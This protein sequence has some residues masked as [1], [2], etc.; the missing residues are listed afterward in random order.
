MS[1]K[2]IKDEYKRLEGD[3]HIKQKRKE[4]QREMAQGRQS[5]AVPGADVVEALESGLRPDATPT[6][7]NKSDQDLSVQSGADQ[8]P[9]T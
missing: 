4:K 6:E 3:P 2:E 5:G 1:K 9:A 7:P 8:P